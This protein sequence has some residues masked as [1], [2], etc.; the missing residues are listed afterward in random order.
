M[1]RIPLGNRAHAVR[2]EQV[3]RVENVFEDQRRLAA[4]LRPRSAPCAPR[5]F[6]NADYINPLVTASSSFTALTECSNMA[7]S[8]AFSSISTIL[9]TPPAP[10]RTGTPT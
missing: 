2:A 8:C 6:R 4:A 9:S 3:R 5:A 7:R 10:S 1:L